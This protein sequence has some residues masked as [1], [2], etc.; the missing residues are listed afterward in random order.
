MT[1]NAGE[2]VERLDHAHIV[3]GNIKWLYDSFLRSSKT[4]WELLKKKAKY[5]TT[6]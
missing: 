5:A 4:V 6:I 2:C 1:P 3:G